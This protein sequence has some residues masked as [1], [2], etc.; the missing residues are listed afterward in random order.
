VKPIIHFAALA[1]AL[2]AAPAA[3]QESPAGPTS[4]SLGVGGGYFVGLWTDASPRL[5]A[6]VEVGTQVSRLAG[7]E[8]EDDYTNVFIQPAVKLFA[9]GEGDVRPYTLLGVY[10]LQYSQRFENP[11]L[12]AEASQRRRELGARVGVGVEWRPLRRVAVGGHAGVSGGY[13]ASRY[14]SSDP[15]IDQ[16]ADGWSAGTFSS[17]LVVHLFF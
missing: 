9:G 6:G 7:D 5:R 10:A 15:E 2:A 14:E 12:G 16:E 13:Q 4:L 8:R 17:G 1:C 11:E 3:A